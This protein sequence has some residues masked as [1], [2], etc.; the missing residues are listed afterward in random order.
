MILVKLAVRN[1]KRNIRRTLLTAGIVM[2]GTALLAT[3]TSWIDGVFGQMLDLIT[4][5][6]GHVRIAK[7][8][9]VRLEQLNPLDENLPDVRDLAT[10]IEQ[11]PGVVGAYPRIQTGVTLTMGE[12]IGDHFGM[13]VGAPLAF[14]AE[15]MDLDSHLVAGAWFSGAPKELVMG[16]SLADDLGASVGSEVVLYGMTQDGA[17][18]GR[19][20]QVVGLVQASN[21]LID[22]Q[23]FLPLAEVQH[24]TDLPASATEVLVY[25]PSRGQATQVAQALTQVPQLQGLTIQAWNTRDPWAGMLGMVDL[26]RGVLFTMMILM[27]ALGVLNTMTMSVLERT[28]E[29]GV[30]RA[31]G[32]RRGQAVLLFVIEALVIA[33]LGGTLG[34]L[35]GG[36]VG[37]YLQVYGVN[38]GDEVTAQFDASTPIQTVLYAK[39]TLKGLV[40]SFLLGLSMALLGALLP[41][42]RAAAILPVEAMRARRTS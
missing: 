27:T 1:A 9:F 14:F 20:T 23:A 33:L 28:G 11:V 42:L 32:M 39:V 37:E 19:V 10:A 34:V 12:D 17:L 41:A 22:S 26:V 4:A 5:S 29:I 38:L 6:T 31:M 35:L 7:S 40:T 3:F 8:E 15:A 25:T 21:P 18:S 30:L 24:L 16:Q 36:A 13:V 2:L